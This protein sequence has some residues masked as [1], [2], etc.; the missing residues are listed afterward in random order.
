MYN[1]PTIAESIDAC[2]R[3]VRTEKDDHIQRRFHMLLLLSGA[4]TA[5]STHCIQHSLR[6]PWRGW[7]V[8]DRRGVSA[9]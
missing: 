2:E 4:V 1:L 5:S 3:L 7:G 9:G 6:A 8:A